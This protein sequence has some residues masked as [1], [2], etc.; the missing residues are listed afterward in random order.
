MRTRKLFWDSASGLKNLAPGLLYK[1]KE[2]IKASFLFPL[3]KK[4]CERGWSKNY[5][6]K[7]C[8]L[9]Q[10]EEKLF[11]EESAFFIKDKKVISAK[12]S[13]N[14]SRR[15]VMYVMFYHCTDN[16]WNSA[17]FA[18]FRNFRNFQLR[19]SNPCHCGANSIELMT[20]ICNFAIL[21]SCSNTT[22]NSRP[23]F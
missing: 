16:L 9:N 1:S 11:L 12:F 21:I 20:M 4:P 7:K 13:V 10:G 3:I 19:E 15:Y 22:S 17:T 6:T 14:I 5:S 8:A 2:K 23:L 18:H